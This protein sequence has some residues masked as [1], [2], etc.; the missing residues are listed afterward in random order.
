[1]LG[2]VTGLTAE[3]RLARRL[4]AT[5]AG[6]GTPKGAA[7]AAATLCD[8]GAT[9]LLS[10]GLAGGLSDVMQPGDIIVPGAVLT[11]DGM[12]ATDDA[13]NAWLGGATG[14]L[15]A[16]DAVIALRTEKRALHARTGADAV[17]L[18]SGAVAE[19]AASRGLPFAVLRAVC[20]PA[21]SDLPP[22]AL[23]ALDARGAIGM[24]AV[25]ASLCRAPRQIPALVRLARQAGLARA[26][27]VRRV[28]VLPAPV[29][30]VT[31]GV[32]ERGL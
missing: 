18:E 25:A 11:K 9:A 26:A 14:T 2:I 23:V 6:G 16:A 30:A 27:L 28:G 20:D 17:D 13:L 3:A 4:G 22:A 5:L 24:I 10:F 15:F 8:E 31:G 7:R 21:M 12:F 32:R 1:M 29:K 19:A